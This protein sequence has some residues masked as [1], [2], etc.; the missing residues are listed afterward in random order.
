MINLKPYQHIHFVGIGGVSTSAIAQILH[1]QNFKI[2]GSDQK[3]S[4]F[5]EHLTQKGISV[6]IGHDAEHISGADAVVYTAAANG[7]NPELLEAKKK[8]IPCYSR[9]EM[10]GYIMAQFERS[11]AVAGTHGKTSTTALLSALTLKAVDPTLLIGGNWKGFNGNLHIGK[12][13]VFI[14]E[15]CEYKR[16]FHSFLPQTAIILN[17][18]EDHL[19]YFTDIEDIIQQFQT[20]TEQ[21]KDNGFLVINGDDPNCKRLTHSPSYSTVTFG[22]KE[23]NDYQAKEIFYNDLGCAEFKLYHKEDFISLIK[24]NIPGEHNI[25]NSLAAMATVLELKLNTSDQ[26]QEILSTFENSD[27]RFQYIGEYKSAH[28]VDDYAHHPNE[29]IASLSTARKIKTANRIITIFQPHTYTRTL[30]LEDEFAEALALSDEII[31]CDVYAAREEK[32]DSFSM[33]QF[34]EKINQKG[35]QAYFMNSFE[36]AIQWINEHLEK[37]DL[38]IT[39]GAGDV[40]EIAYRLVSNQ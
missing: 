37:D 39:M 6:F 19:D 2:T 23:S 10:L 31:L 4:L 1:F 24:L 14:T 3:S 34:I 5:T 38:V 12:S 32:P 13:D 29:I 22:L 28:I 11:I 20:F 26:I 30:A 9:A 15:A 33:N 40:N 18:D 21:I 25:Y 7:K 27:R 17:I 35:K 16:S 8:N 36:D